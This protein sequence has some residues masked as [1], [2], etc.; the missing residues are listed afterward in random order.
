[1]LLQDGT[2]STRG[3]WV[4]TSTTTAGRADATNVAPP[5]GTVSALEE[6]LKEI[7]HCL[8]TKGSGTDVLAK[9][10]LHFN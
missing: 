9:C 6:H 1:V 3:Y 5:G 4:R 2:A 10:I 7:G 8:E